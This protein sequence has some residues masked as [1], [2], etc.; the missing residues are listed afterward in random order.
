MIVSTA[1]ALEGRRIVE[2]VG[3]VPGEAAMG[4]S[5]FRD[6]VA[7]VRA[8]VGVRAGACEKVPKDARDVAVGETTNEAAARGA[9]AVGG[10]GL[11]HEVL[12]ERG[13]MLMVSANGTAV[14]VE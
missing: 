13:S 4:A 12:R 10:V 3:L 2:Y 6:P 5:I 1:P 14:V 8:I 7:A 11:D 9:N